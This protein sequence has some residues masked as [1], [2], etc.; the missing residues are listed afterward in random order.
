MYKLNFSVEGMVCSRL[1]QNN[2][3]RITELDGVQTATVDF[4]TKLA[5]VTLIVSTNT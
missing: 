1:C 5:T 4:D 3:G 2:S